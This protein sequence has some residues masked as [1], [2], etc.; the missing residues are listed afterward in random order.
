MKPRH[1]SR[2]CRAIVARRN[3]ATPSR[4]SSR[5]ERRREEITP[6]PL[7]FVSVHAAPTIALDSAG[8]WG[9]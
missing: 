9:S 1:K 6:P 4:A 7:G 5:E 2:D 3:R 8:G